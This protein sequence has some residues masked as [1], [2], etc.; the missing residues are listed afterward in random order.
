LNF[1]A[2][3]K[4]AKEMV[5]ISFE[6]E[7]LYM[8]HSMDFGTLDMGTRSSDTLKASAKSELKTRTLYQ[9]AATNFVMRNFY[10]HVR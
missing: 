1:G 9:T 5:N 2:D 3:V 7:K 8:S 6:D 4:S 10:A